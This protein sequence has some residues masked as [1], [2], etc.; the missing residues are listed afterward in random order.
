MTIAGQPLL[1][2]GTY[3]AGKV[4]AFT[5]FTPAEGAHKLPALPLD[6]EFIENPAYRAYFVVFSTLL[7]QALRGQPSVATDLL[8]QHETPL[9]E[10]LNRLPATRIALSR[11]DGIQVD[12]E[13]EHCQVRVASRDGYAHLVHLHVDWNK[14]PGRPYLTEFSDND[15]ELLPDEIKYINVDWRN[16]N[17]SVRSAWNADRQ[18]RKCG[19]GFDGFL[20]QK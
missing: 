5:G 3:G 18:R 9:F 8:A 7:Q 17:Q 4:V 2:V 16:Q 14:A 13:H 12:G 10:T 6:Q 1:A 15:F 19:R 11:D 20:M